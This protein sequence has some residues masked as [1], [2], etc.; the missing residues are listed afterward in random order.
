MAPPHRILVTG[1]AGYIG[2]FVCQELA[3]CG[4]LPIVFDDFSRGRTPSGIP[5][6]A[7][8]GSMT[9][10]RLGSVMAGHRPAA[11]IHLAGGRGGR[12]QTASGVAPARFQTE[13]KPVGRPESAP[14]LKSRARAHSD[15]KPVPTFAECA[16]EDPNLGGTRMLLAAMAE[17]EVR[18]IV[19]ASSAAVYGDAG[20]V[21]AGED[22]PLRGTSPYGH[23]K[24]AAEGLVRAWGD[25]PDR[26]WVILRYANAAGADPESMLGWY[27]GDRTIVPSAIAVASGERAAFELFGAA[28]PTRDRTAVRD[29]VHC[30]DIAAATVHVVRQCLGCGLKEI[31]NVASGRGVSVAEIVAAAEQVTSRRIP[32]IRHDA[33]DGEVASLVLSADRLARFGFTPR[34]SDLG[35]ILSSAWAWHRRAPD[36]PISA[37]GH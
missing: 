3:R 8:H 26:G 24:I 25:E 30:W 33:R 34:H 1:A 23:A 15:A 2:R 37:H 4:F 6:F 21:H 32:V 22:A 5:G 17:L 7:E 9:E 18:H 13:W 10:E 36:R 28:F 31:F 29:F 20:A 12:H 19:L 11:V 16:L 14:D 35:T 27:P